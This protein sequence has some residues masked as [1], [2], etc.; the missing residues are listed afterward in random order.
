VDITV[1]VKTAKNALA[2]TIVN[3]GKSASV[4]K[5][6][7]VITTNMTMKKKD[8]S[9][10]KSINHIMGK[11]AA[12]VV[13]S[14][15]KSLAKAWKLGNIFKWHKDCKRILTTIA[16]VLQNSLTFK[17]KKEKRV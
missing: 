11:N 8:I 14:V 10:T 12:G 6:A 9:I 3:V 15:K 16:S 4:G 13:V 1:A 7:N 5:S 2:E 17:E